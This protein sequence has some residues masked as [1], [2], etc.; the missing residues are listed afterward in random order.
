[1]LYETEEKKF[2]MKIREIASATNHPA[3]IHQRRFLMNEL[4]ASKRDFDNV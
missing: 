3:M 1:M 4:N 2:G